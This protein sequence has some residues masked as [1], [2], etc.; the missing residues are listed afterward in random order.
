MRT[1]KRQLPSPFCVEWLRLSPLRR[2]RGFAA[3]SWRLA[4]E[5]M[6]A[7]A[8]RKQV[9]GNINYNAAMSGTELVEG[10]ITDDQIERFGLQGRSLRLGSA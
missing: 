7:D 4:A 5:D 3:Y 10:G 2:Q 6:T 8:F 9:V 1:R